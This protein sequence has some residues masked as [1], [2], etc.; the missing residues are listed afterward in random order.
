MPLTS[1]LRYCRIFYIAGFAFA[2]DAA[3]G[4]ET[5]VKSTPFAQNSS[6]F[7]TYTTTPRSQADLQHIMGDDIQEAAIAIPPYFVASASANGYRWDMMLEKYVTAPDSIGLARFNY[8]A[9]HAN[10]AD[11]AALDDYITDLEATDVKTLT[12]DEAI[13]F[14]ANLYNAVTIKVVIDNYPVKSIREIKSGWR[15]GPWKRDLVTVGGEKLSLD[16]IEHDILRK[17]YPS[18]LIHYMVNC[19]SIG[20]PNLKAGLWMVETLGADREAAARAFINSP[21]GAR[22][23]DKGLK[24]SSIYKW[25]KE[26]FGGN[27]DGVL[28]HLREYAD[29]DLAAA[30]DGGAKIIDYGYSW[31]LNE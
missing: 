2:G 4:A 14:W 19:A 8:G 30:I 18:P 16:N 1:I 13:V 9:L 5:P 11:R 6:V 17:Q 28:A 15:P 23:T 31:S 29:A 24:V 25:F 21:R 7:I 12:D 27:K 3:L 20:C 26:D 10:T 22:I